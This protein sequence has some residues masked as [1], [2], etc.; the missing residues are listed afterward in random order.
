[1]LARLLPFFLG[2]EEGPGEPDKTIVLTIGNFGGAPAYLPGQNIGA[3]VSGTTTYTQGGRNINITYVAFASGLCVLQ[4][5][6]I[7]N[8]TAQSA[9][10]SSLPSQIIA[11]NV[12]TPTRTTTFS[13]ITHYSQFSGVDP[14]TQIGYS[15]S[16]GSTSGVFVVG[17]NVRLDLYF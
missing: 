14:L 1:M 6:G 11:T 15:R 8:P 12:T 2:E 16:S 17:Q 4:V 13:S 3:L 10:E 7:P 9:A 5:T